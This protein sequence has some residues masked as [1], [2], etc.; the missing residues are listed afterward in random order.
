MSLP[1]AA[2]VKSKFWLE[3]WTAARF[4]IYAEFSQVL[5]LLLSM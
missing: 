3:S 4:V 5:K 1:E 2:E